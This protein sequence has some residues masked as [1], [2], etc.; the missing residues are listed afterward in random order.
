MTLFAI[1]WL[2]VFA[3]VKYTE[4]SGIVVKP[5]N[6]VT[7]TSMKKMKISSEVWKQPALENLVQF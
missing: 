5:Q 1:S 6:P 2:Y 7:A 3:N 4:V